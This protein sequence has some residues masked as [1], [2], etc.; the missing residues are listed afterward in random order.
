MAGGVSA[1]SG[2]MLAANPHA[3]PKPTALLVRAPVNVPYQV[4][5]LLLLLLAL[6][7]AVVGDVKLTGAA[8]IKMT[9]Y[10]S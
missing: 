2:Q 4:L 7:Y 9:F 6:L 10:E 5:F 1:S 3:S 8:L